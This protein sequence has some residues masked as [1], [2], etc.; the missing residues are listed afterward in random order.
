MN[1]YEAIQQAILDEMANGIIPWHKPYT[2]P[3]GAMNYVSRRPYGLLNQMLLPQKGEY[4]TPKQAAELG[5]DFSGEKTSRI[6]FFR[7]VEK[8]TKT[9]DEDGNEIKEEYPVLKSYNVLHVSQVRGIES[10]IASETGK[11]NLR[12]DDVEAAVQ[13]F[14]SKFG[15]TI[16][17][18]SGKEP[19]YDPVSDTVTL[20]YLK[21]YESSSA[22]YDDLFRLLAHA[23]GKAGRLDR[24]VECPVGA[25]GFSREELVA[26]MAAAMLLNHFEVD[27]LEVW[28]NSVAYMKGWMDAIGSDKYMFV[29]AS[30]RA[31]KAAKMILGEA[32]EITIAA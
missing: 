13:A 5:G 16:A 32:A 12:E 7:M 21:Q 27:T 3:E 14:C 25:D 9:Y 17:H 29:W 2:G 18:A 23:T 24:G 6:Y 20:P 26:E 11:R 8:G 19:S 28:R 1:A 10:K 15:V 4:L 22:Y 30:S 31:E